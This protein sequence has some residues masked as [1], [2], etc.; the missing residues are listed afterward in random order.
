LVLIGS[1]CSALPGLAWA[2]T[3]APPAVQ[4]SPSD[5]GQSQK[6]TTQ[7]PEIVVEER[8]DSMLGIAESST[9]GTIGA[10][11]LEERPILRP[12][13]VL[14]AMPGVIVTQ[15]SGDG[16]ANQY[17]LRGF[18]LDHGTDL[19]TFVNGVPINLPS[20]AHGEG[21]TDLTFLIP[22]LIQKIDY[23]K[24]P[25]FANVGDFG[26]AGSENIQY[27]QTLPAGIAKFEVGSFNYE[28][29]LVADSMKVGQGNLLFAAETVHTDGPWVVPEGYLKF[30]GLLTYSQ[31]DTSQG[32]SASALAYH[33]TWGATNQVPE[34]AVAEGLISRF[35]SMNP[36]DGGFTDR[37][38]LEGE[39]HQAD[40]HSA[41][42]VVAYAYYYNMGLW[43]DF[44]YYLVDPVHGDQ[45]E[46]RDTRWVQ[47]VRASRTYFTQWCNM[48]VENTFGLDVRNDVI[49]DGLFNTQDRMSLSTVRTDNVLETDVAPYFENKIQWLPKFRTVFGLRYD[50]INFDNNNTFTYATNGPNPADSGD[51]FAYAPEPKLSL[52]FG[53]WAKTEFYLNGGMGFHTDDAR[54]A[55]T[56]Q[57]P[58]TG[59][60]VQRALPI[61]QTVG[62]EVGVRTLA[63]PN[64]QST[65]TFW[66]LRLQSELIFDGDTGTTVPS[67]D[68]DLRKGVEWA[69]YYT[70][71][72]WLTIDADF[73]DS[74]AHFLGNPVGGD[75]V[76]EAANVVISSGVTIHD[77]K[78]WSTS[79]RL[80]YFGPRYLTQDGTERSPS[81]TLLYYNISYK[82][83]KTWTI[84]G[85]IFNLLNAKAYD[86]DYY[87]QYRLTPTSSP[88]SGDVFHP[89][90]PRTFRVALTMRF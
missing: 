71:T 47:G 43:N 24:G 38:T 4:G 72:K 40:E 20:N 73:A 46:Q 62:G 21:Y 61:A 56:T 44:T 23:Q 64:L 87:Y 49:H 30:N 83:N 79:L 66:V 55:N 70:P 12:G 57:D 33:G 6:G 59:L 2:D 26:S 10:Q 74:S 65:L 81:T 48:P 9:Q 86:I 77:L 82:L 14:E 1:F 89:V 78:G 7:L 16:K 22:E 31:G 8:S 37:Y 11:Q 39:W 42:K 45:F 68:P 80:R 88:V 76:P 15:H 13:E 51:R 50:F 27:V 69:N 3:D 17:F 35:G 60:P 52:I 54:G 41:T 36:T 34:L 85:D 90:E 18:N 84:E 19:A 63:V 75:Y 25:Y 29:G 28:R 67:P 5:T 32:F 53:P 58:T